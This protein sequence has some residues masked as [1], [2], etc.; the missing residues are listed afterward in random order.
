MKI[1]K[2]CSEDFSGMQKN[3]S[4]R[5]CSSCNKTVID[6]TKMST[7]EIQKYLDSSTGEVCGRFKSLQLEQKN[8][9]EKIIFQLREW[10]S[11]FNVRPMRIAFLALISGITAFTSSC[12]GKVQNSYDSNQKVKDP[13]ADSLKIKQAS[14]N[15]N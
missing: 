4:G 6:F 14:S 13:K 1:E 9:F 5:L 15:K 12:M 7:G 11:G 10:V 3:N 2:P 8:S